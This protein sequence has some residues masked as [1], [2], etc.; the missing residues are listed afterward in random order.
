MISHRTFY[1]SLFTV[2]GLF[3]SL[4]NAATQGFP[5]RP[6]AMVV[7]FAAGGP[8]DTLARIVGERMRTRWA[9]P[10]SLKM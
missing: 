6:I 8:T 5:T 7:P 9:S 4:S 2:A 3:A 10:S 1:T